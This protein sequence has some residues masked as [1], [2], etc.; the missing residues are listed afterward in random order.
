MRS[1]PRKLGEYIA[2]LIIWVGLMLL[3]GLLSQN[4]LTLGTLNALANRV[5]ALTV[6]AAGMTLVLIIG[7]ID[8]SVGSVLGLGGAVVGV[9][10]VDWHWPVWGA[11]LLCISLGSMAGCLTLRPRALHLLAP[12]SSQSESL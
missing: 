5:P 7:G 1:A 12:T 6:V 8:L 4:F 10:I 2:L 9:A 3:F 11:A